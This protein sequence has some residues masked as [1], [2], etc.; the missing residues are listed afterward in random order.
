MSDPALL[1]ATLLIS[2]LSLCLLRGKSS[3]GEV[4]YY[5]GETIR[6]INKALGDPTRKVTDANICAVACLTLLEVML[7]DLLSRNH[8]HN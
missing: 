1:S 7:F 3:N 2:A 6:Q 5:M 8:A 4:I